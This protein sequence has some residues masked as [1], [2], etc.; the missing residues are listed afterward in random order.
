M[1]SPFLQTS[2]KVFGLNVLSE[3][4]LPELISSQGP[5]DVTI[6]FGEIGETI[7][8]PFISGISYE[9]VPGRFL[10]K[11][12]GVASY[13][14]ENGITITI[15]KE[16]GGS[17]DEIR[18]FLL[19][20]A[21][22]ALI[23]QR[24]LL[25]FHG[26]AVVMDQKAII[27]S[28]SSGAGKSTLAAGFIDGGKKLLADDVCVISLGENDKPIV[29]PGY[30][31]MKLWDDSLE[32]LGHQSK[33]LKN[34]KR[35]IK[36]YALP[37]PSDFLNTP[38]ELKGIYVIVSHDNDEIFI[39]DLNGV[40]K[41]NIINRNTYR[42]NFLKGCGIVEE[43]FKHIEAI[44]RKCFVKYLYRPKKGFHIEELMKAVED[45]LK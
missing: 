9:A 7:D 34:I 33:I 2:Y 18:L 36:K 4:P 8:K 20:S 14:V 24:G 40:E 35:G 43:H 22:G 13:L 11:V 16:E 29:H 6:T 23:H 26:S 42:L 41:F 39:K 17:D 32:K 30:P 25:P 5:P 10:M 31:Q 44:S 1:T 37:V 15:D 27:F 45:D 3:L 19:G 28:G 12:N 38:L 21:F